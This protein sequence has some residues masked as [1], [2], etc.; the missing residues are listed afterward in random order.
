MTGRL[1]G[2][3]A[4]VTG[5]ARGIGL[6]VATAFAEE[7]ATVYGA[8]KDG[9]TLGAAM[10]ALEEAGLAAHA[11]TTDVS[12]EAEVERLFGQVTERHQRLDVLANIAGVIALEPIET[13]TCEIWD[14]TIS[15]NLR[16][17]FLCARAAVPVMKRARRGS[18]IN[19]S[20]NAG[21]SGWAN[22]T[23]YCASKFALEG[24]SRALALELLSFG[25]A[26]NTMTP[27]TAV[28]TAMSEITYSEEM[29]RKWRDP[30]VIAPAFV[31]L[32]MQ[33]ATGVNNQYVD[34]WHL[35]ETLQA[36]GW[37]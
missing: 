1:N 32:A 24:F 13:T 35:S 19:M 37:T 14:W 8:G 5:A 36:N 27:G 9:E 16:G 20:S 30:A 26:V 23:A 15:V 34:A 17:P 12:S 6:A 21:I 7:G 29:K 18:I 3:V 31:H 11:V 22:E 28:R 2:K 33:D 10:G 4:I 25:I